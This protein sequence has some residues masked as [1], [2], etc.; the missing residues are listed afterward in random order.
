[1]KRY[2]V[3]L[4]LGCSEGFIHPSKWDWQTLLDLS[5]D[6]PV[7]VASVEAFEDDEDGKDREYCD[8]CAEVL[9]IGNEHAIT[10]IPVP[11]G[12]ANEGESATLCN[13]CFH[14]ISNHPW[15]GKSR[16]EIAAI[17]SKREVKS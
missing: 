9:S 3:T 7:E 13:L 5:S 14:F 1:M 16:D 15:H 4:A 6:E 8:S 17:Y 12:S 2:K 11:I 10:A